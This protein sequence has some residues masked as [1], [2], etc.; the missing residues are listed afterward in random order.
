MIFSFDE[1]NLTPA[2]LELIVTQAGSGATLRFYEGTQPSDA[3]VAPTGE[4]L[5]TLPLANPIGAVTAGVSGTSKASLTITPPTTENG[6]ASGTPTFI[7][8][9]KS[10]GGAVIYLDVG[11]AGADA[12]CTLTPDTITAGAPL[13]V[14]SFEIIGV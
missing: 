11:A 8:I 2:M 7:G 10:G 14:S 4:L 1:V 12:F 9:F 3:S 6:T 13:S 5:A